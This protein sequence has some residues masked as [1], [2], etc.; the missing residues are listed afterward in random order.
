MRSFEIRFEFES[1]VRFDS[2]KTPRE[3]KPPQAAI[4]NFV[5]RY[6]FCWIAKFGENVL[7]HSQAIASGIYSVLGF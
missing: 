1:A 7:N 4:L 5:E 2:K 6:N 3:Y